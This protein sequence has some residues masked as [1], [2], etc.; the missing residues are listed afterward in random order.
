MMFV[1]QKSGMSKGPDVHEVLSQEFG[2]DSI[3]F[4]KG[5]TM[6]SH[7]NINLLY[8]AW[9][10]RQENRLRRAIHRNC[11]VIHYRYF[12]VFLLLAHRRYGKARE[13]CERILNLYP[14]DHMA[15]AVMGRFAERTRTHARRRRLLRDSP[16][17]RIGIR[18]RCCSGRG[19]TRSGKRCRHLGMNSKPSTNSSVPAHRVSY[20][21]SPLSWPIVRERKWQDSQGFSKEIGKRR[22]H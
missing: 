9:I 15:G 19:S 4:R 10:N 16:T 13:E 18:S 2:N 22:D 1:S 11:T 20:C 12:L 7:L 5:R 8:E 6:L 3:S 21:T 14:N 17:G